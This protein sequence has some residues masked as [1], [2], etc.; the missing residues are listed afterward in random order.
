MKIAMMADFFSPCV[1]FSLSIFPHSFVMFLLM[2]PQRT[3]LSMYTNNDLA[4]GN[5]RQSEKKLILTAQQHATCSSNSKSNL[6]RALFFCC[7]ADKEVHSSPSETNW[8]RAQCRRYLS[9]YALQIVSH[10]NPTIWLK[11]K[12]DYNELL[13]SAHFYSYVHRTTT[14]YNVHRKNKKKTWMN[15]HQSGRYYKLGPFL[16][17]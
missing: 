17:W 11:W 8:I 5:G 7:A 9:A 6:K 4:H 15:H 3:E 14:T 16:H 13:I 2:Y 1:S 12:C 10:G